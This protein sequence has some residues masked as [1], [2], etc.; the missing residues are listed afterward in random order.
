MKTI[1]ESLQKR[2]SLYSKESIEIEGLKK[3]ENSC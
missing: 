1:I 2:S 3:E